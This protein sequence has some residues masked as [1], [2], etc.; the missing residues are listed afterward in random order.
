MIWKQPFCGEN[1]H[2]DNSKP[3]VADCSGSHRFVSVTASMMSWGISGYVAIPTISHD[4]PWYQWYQWYQDTVIPQS[5]SSLIYQ[6][7]IGKNRRFTLISA[8][9]S[10]FISL[11]VSVDGDQTSRQV[12]P[13]APKF[14]TSV[15]LRSK[16]EILDQSSTAAFQRNRR[17]FRDSQILLLDVASKMC[18]TLVLIY[19]GFISAEIRLSCLASPSVPGYY[20]KRFTLFNVNFLCALYLMNDEYFFF[21]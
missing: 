1:L 10:V 2:T 5:S 9:R 12:R 3:L 4:K 18:F 20:L 7:N 6:T 19:T 8:H 13:R 16:G 15:D 14:E 17:R 11:D 21:Y